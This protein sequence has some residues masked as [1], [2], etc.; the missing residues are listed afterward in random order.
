MLKRFSATSIGRWSTRRPRRAIAAWLAFVVVCVLAPSARGSKQLQ[1][2]AVGESA[3]GYALMLCAFG[4][5]VASMVPVLLAVTAV[6]AAFG[7]LGPISQAFPLDDSVK[8]VVLLIGMAVGV[9][10]AL[11]YVLRCRE[12]RQRGCSS[13]EALE[14]TARTS[15]RSV[16]IAG[17]TVAIA[18]AGQFRDGMS[19]D[20]AL[21]HGIARTAGV[22]SSAAPVMVGVFSLFAAA[23]SLDLKQAGAGLA[24]A[25]LLDATVA[26]GCVCPRP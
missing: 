6:I 1:N 3:Q 16:L 22:V 26:R 19:T 2:G 21:R 24:V 23:S 12:E 17:R 7:L 4:A 10:N 20:A 25:V 8:T 15:G 13:R 5:L 14:R 9:D 11:S 18:M